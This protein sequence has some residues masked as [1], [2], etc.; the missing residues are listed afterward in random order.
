MEP[1][2]LALDI[3]T[4]S[5]RTALFDATGQRIVESTAQEAYPLHTQTD[6]TAELDPQHLLEAIQRCLQQTFLH[7]RSNPTLAHRPITAVG[8]SCFWHSLVGLDS[9]N[10]PLTPIITWADSRCR[11]DAAR[12]R[13][14]FSEQQLHQLTGCMLRT[15]FW[16]AQLRR[17]RREQP[18]LFDS[19]HQWV[20]PAEWI[21][22]A[23]LGHSHCAIAMATGTGIFNPNSL[24]WEPLL[25]Q[26]SGLSSPNALPPISDEPLYPSASIA[27]QFPELSKT[28]WFPAIGDGAA[29]NL[30]SG[31]STP[32]RAAINVGTSAALRIL[33]S[34]THAESPYGL[35]CY[36]VDA[37]RFLI[38]GA[39]SNAGNLRAWALRELRTPDPEQLETLL[40]SRPGPDHGLTIL[41]FWTAERAPTWN[42]DIRG[43]ILGLTQAT[44]ALDL[45]Q[46]VTE[47]T[48]HRLALIAE[49][50][51][52]KTGITPQFLVSGGI[53]H[54]HSAMQR[55][56]DVLHYPVYA[57]PE[58][59]AS[60]RGAAI[61][62]MEK[63]NLPV[64]PLPET[65]PIQP[66][67]SIAHRYHLARQKQKA[68]EELLERHSF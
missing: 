67:E 16:P 57:N 28:P 24:Q 52:S 41:P 35:F 48:Y 47:A 51:I 46:A 63:L 36:R 53:Q 30:G 18:S 4:S 38:G 60:I 50:L 58:R 42:E 54:S 20:S 40:A 6:G 34:G 9:E 15:S 56:A 45:L 59:E 31:C 3:G 64:T 61:Y 8:T 23:L 62:A 55:M 26:A 37:Q 25:Q 39:V 29:S 22:R 65:Q 5:S 13:E 43:A 12:L 27:Q 49:A 68:L 19:V 44:S 10:T 7:A 14:E 17:L 33:Q 32:N 2:F 1:L 21:H 11:P 66:N